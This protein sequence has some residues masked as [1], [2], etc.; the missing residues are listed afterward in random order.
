MMEA[1]PAAPFE[2][3]EPDL[4][5]EF[6]IVALDAPAQFGEVNQ[7]MEGNVL[8]KRREPVLG[9]LLLAFG[10]LDQQPFFRMALAAIEI[11]PRG[12]NPHTGKARGQLLGRTL[13]PRD[14]VPGALGQA[15]C[16]FLF[17]GSGPVPGA[18]TV[19]FDRMPAT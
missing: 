10:P 11:A 13:S 16:E 5:L 14:C 1:A 15:E 2:M 6:L 4:L 17:A 19:V 3:A 7:T 18:H 8:R 12:A 9:R